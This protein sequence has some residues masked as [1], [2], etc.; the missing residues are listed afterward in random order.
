MIKDDDIQIRINENCPYRKCI[1]IK[2]TKCS[3]MK[4]WKNGHFL[5]RKLGKKFMNGILVALNFLLP[6]HL[7]I[8]VTNQCLLY[9]QFQL[10]FQVKLIQ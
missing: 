8:N 3:K 1:V 7:V 2:I 4:A 6:F 9:S 5:K 10:R